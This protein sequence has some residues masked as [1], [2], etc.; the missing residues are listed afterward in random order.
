MVSQNSLEIKGLKDGLLVHLDGAGKWQERMAQLIERI[1]QQPAFF[2]GAQL[3]L[4]VGERAIRRHE[5]NTLLKDLAEREVTLW[6]VVSESMTTASTTRKLGLATNLA[7]HEKPTRPTPPEL[8]PDEA[9]WRLDDEP[10]AE[11]P[12]ISPEEVGT[13]GVLVKRTV[14]NGRTVHSDG[15][16]V[17]IGDVNPGGEI[18]AGG[19]IIVWGRLRGT[20]HAGAQGDEDAA[21]CALDMSPMQLRIAGHIATSP[22]DKQRTPQPEVARVRENRIVVENWG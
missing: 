22:E 7:A 6:A 20:V 13:P 9:F 11:T 2:R 19:D 12:A 10:D 21:V 8:T 18:I 14:R 5:L 4:D 16:V 3:A 15:H 17:I 1:D